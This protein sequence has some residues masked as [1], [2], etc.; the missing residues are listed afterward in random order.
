MVK[1]QIIRNI[2]VLKDN[3]FESLE[4]KYIQ[5]G[6]NPPK[7]DLRRWK[8]G[9][10]LKGVTL[11][12]EEAKE[13]VL[14]LSGELGFSEIYDGNEDDFDD[15]IDVE[16]EESEIIE[17]DEEEEWSDDGYNDDENLR[18]IDFRT[19]FVRKS[20]KECDQKG[21]DYID[22]IAS[23]PMMVED[24]YT[25]IEFPAIYCYD[26]NIFYVS[27]DVYNR[28]HEDGKILCQLL[29]EEE[30]ERYREG[31]NNEN[32]SP[33]GPLYLLGY[34]VAEGVLTA[35]ERKQLLGWIIANGIMKKSRVISYLEFFIRVRQGQTNMTHAIQKWREDKDYLT[36]VSSFG[37][38]APP[39]G[40][41][42]FVNGKHKENY[43]DDYEELPFG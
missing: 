10:P 43:Y 18:I 1:Y 31:F 30:Y 13:L 29:T 16:E 38:N 3:Q 6:N 34:T 28:L 42:R 12:E 27:T 20:M 4:L 35:A 24:T 8:N 32:L 19:F 22:V 5:W 36:G 2:A 7:Y 41:V 15:V 40:V 39:M 17:E 14:A 11:S 33:K 26:C 21:H 23:V 37:K 25:N 9:S